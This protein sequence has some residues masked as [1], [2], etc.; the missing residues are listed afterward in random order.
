MLACTA[1]RENFANA[2]RRTT[3]NLLRNRTSAP[4][5]HFHKRNV[6]LL[7]APWPAA[8]SRQHQILSWAP[9]GT[10]VVW[11]TTMG[12]WFT[13]SQPTER[14]AMNCPIAWS[15]T[16]WKKVRLR[17]ISSDRSSDNLSQPPRLATLER[18]QTAFGRL[19]HAAPPQLL[20][21]L[22]DDRAPLYQNYYPSQPKCTALN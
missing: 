11:F 22:N 17:H 21:F 7:T 4:C 19:L 18:R 12:V 6:E 3:L 16:G 20:L 5:S 10:V 2:L 14:V 13:L 1:S 9:R 8:D 15:W